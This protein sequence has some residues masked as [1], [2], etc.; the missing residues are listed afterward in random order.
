[1][2]WIKQDSL[3]GVVL[4]YVLSEPGNETINSIT[5]DLDTGGEDRYKI[6]KSIFSAVENLAQRGFV[7][8]GHGPNKSNSELWP[9]EMIYQESGNFEMCSTTE[10]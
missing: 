2:S 6:Y 9:N 5:E 8:I 1:M 4:S 10:V 7:K 3:R